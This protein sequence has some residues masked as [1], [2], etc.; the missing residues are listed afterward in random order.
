MQSSIPTAIHDRWRK[1]RAMRQLTPLWP[2]LLVHRSK[3]VTMILHSR[4]ESVRMTFRRSSSDPAILDEVLA[5]DIYACPQFRT[6][7]CIVMDFGAHIGSFTTG[8]LVGRPDARAFCIEPNP[9]SYSLLVQNLQ[10]NRVLARSVC[11]GAAL[12]SR[13]TLAADRFVRLDFPDGQQ[14]VFEQFQVS[15][16]GRW[17]TLGVSLDAL[18]TLLEPGV[19]I[20][21]KMDIEGG[22]LPLLN[23]FHVFLKNHPVSMLFMEFHGTPTQQEEWVRQLGAIGFRCEVNGIILRAER[24]T[25]AA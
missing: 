10:A 3:L 15:P 9:F 6:G 1:A 25:A 16:Q 12:V 14:D 17:I 8:F 23:E 22:E 5:N 7:R 20:V 19:P 13:E 2:T 11:L 24:A 21:L 18:S 4:G